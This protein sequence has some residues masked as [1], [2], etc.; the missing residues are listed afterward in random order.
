MPVATHLLDPLKQAVIAAAEDMLGKFSAAKGSTTST[1]PTSGYHFRP[2][3]AS[4]GVEYF[5]LLH[6]GRVLVDGADVHRQADTY[7][8]T[9]RAHRPLQLDPGLCAAALSSAWGDARCFVNDDASRL[10]Y[11]LD[12]PQRSRGPDADPDAETRVF[13]RYKRAV[14]A[15]DCALAPLGLPG[16][17][18]RPQP[19]VSLAWARLH[20]SEASARGPAGAVEGLLFSGSTAREP[21]GHV[22]GRVALTALL[23]RWGSGT[24]VDADSPLSLPLLVLKLG[25]RHLVLPLCVRK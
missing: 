19:H 12:L 10:F 1:S 18:A 15:V 23:Q 7:R 4:S 21:A 14:A 13:R 25:N 20:S 16:Y 11:A 24:G 5:D 3:T 9:H 8:G 6:G 17:Y 2:A 22:G